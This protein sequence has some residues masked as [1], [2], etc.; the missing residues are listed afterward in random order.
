MRRG[1]LSISIHV[2]VYWL[3][4]FLLKLGR[5]QKKFLE[6]LLLVFFLMNVI[7]A[8]VVCLRMSGPAL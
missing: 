3:L 5:P 1:S 6:S 2:L 4:M 7:P 8:H